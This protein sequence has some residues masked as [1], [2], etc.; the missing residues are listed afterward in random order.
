VSTSTGRAAGPTTSKSQH[1]L[2]ASRC[3]LRRGLTYFFSTTF[4]REVSEIPAREFEV[5]RQHARLGNACAG[6]P[7]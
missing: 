5:D 7:A 2:R 1:R 4:Q 3:R 6:Q